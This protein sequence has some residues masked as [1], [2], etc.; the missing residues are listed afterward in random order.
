[1]PK[2][3]PNA[4]LTRWGDLPDLRRSSIAPTADEKRHWAAAEVAYATSSFS[5]DSGLGRRLRQ[6]LP[7]ISG[8][9]GKREL[10][11]DME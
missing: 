10:T 7:M 1:M 3:P 2:I 4:F 6:L 11:R 5:L 8:H 9:G